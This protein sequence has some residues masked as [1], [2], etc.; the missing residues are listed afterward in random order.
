MIFSLLI[1]QAWRDT[2]LAGPDVTPHLYLTL[3][4]RV[5][6]TESHPRYRA[7]FCFYLGFTSSVL[8]HTG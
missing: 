1:D 4:E 8:R 6:G 7:I 2:K 5:Y 3:Q